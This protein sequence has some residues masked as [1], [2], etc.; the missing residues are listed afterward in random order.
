MRTLTAW[1]V[2]KPEAIAQLVK[3]R[4]NAHSPNGP[5]HGAGVAGS[6]GRLHFTNDGIK[7]KRP[8]LFRV[9]GRS[10]EQPSPEVCS[11]PH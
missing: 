11:Q 1:I 8:K 3:N 10:F 4:P 9:M 2:S 7:T 5:M 6:G